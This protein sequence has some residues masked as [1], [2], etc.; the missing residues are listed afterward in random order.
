MDITQDLSAPVHD[1]TTRKSFGRRVSFASKTQVRMFKKPKNSTGSPQSSPDAS[2][3]NSVSNENDYP[4]QNSRR[5]SSARY[6][7]AD[8]DLTTVVAPGN[9]H[10][11]GS[12]ILDEEFDHDDDNFSDDMEVTEAIQ[13]N[14][15]RKHS[16]SMG[17][18]PLSQSG[19]SREVDESQ[20][21]I[22]DD[23]VQSEG[24]SEEHSQAME[25]TV[26]LGQSLRPPAERDEVWLALK[27]MTHSGNEPPEPD[28]ASDDSTR[29]HERN[30]MDLDIAMER[31]KRARDSLPLSS[32]TT[33]QVDDEH[34]KQDDTFTSTE[35]SFE[36]DNDGNKTMNLS[37]VMGRDSMARM[38][39]DYQ[40]SNMDESE[41]Y[42]NVAQS[43]PR[44]SLLP[45]ETPRSPVRQPIQSSVFQP[46]PRTILNPTSAPIDTPSSTSRADS[47]SKSKPPTSPSKGG[48]LKPTFTAAFAPPV[49]KPSPKKATTPGTQV[50]IKRPRPSQH[51]G[52]ESD[53]DRPSPA[54]KQALVDRW[55]GIKE[56]KEDARSAPEPTAAKG[57]KPKPLSPSKKALFQSSSTTD[58]TS[59][60]KRP[61]GYFARRKSLAVG[62]NQPSTSQKDNTAIPSSPTKISNGVK[63]L[64]LGSA[65][66]DVWRRF[67][68]S[69]GSAPNNAPVP[70]SKMV[71]KGA[72]NNIRQQSSEVLTPSS[73]EIPSQVPQTASSPERLVAPAIVISQALED[74]QE[75]NQDT[76][77]DVEGTQQWREGVEPGE[78]A[79]DEQ[80][81]C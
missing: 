15:L 9:F 26:P 12:A 64:S 27:Q 31:L 71:D 72:E 3:Y 8:M 19:P 11:A 70:S 44:P 21:D 81:V 50:P 66:S 42:G 36:S 56:T 62:F 30:G 33:P 58:H 16:L 43:T 35:D 78:Y 63:R 1:N 77:I 73:P 67:E 54:K 74:S 60:I 75:T 2:H 20:S 79:E 45:L 29:Y 65:P 76:D 80:T 32:Q 7:I 24:T 13:G 38:S 61:S 41:V 47:P 59:G 39:L 46:P 14:F 18:R 4:G 37:Q 6:S 49:I 55:M 40:D 68:R 10:G 51:D 48:R 52:L 23:S 22:G 53:L 5:R 57:S 34:A 25:F 17:R 69:P 28:L